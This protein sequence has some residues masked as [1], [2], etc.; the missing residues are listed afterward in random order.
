MPSTVSDLFS[1]VGLEPAG[2]VKWGEPLPERRVPGVYVVALS[3]DPD[4]T[5][6]MRSFPQLAPHRFEELLRTCPGLSLDGVRPSVDRLVERLEAFWIKDE[7]VLYIGLS[8]RPVGTRMREYYNTPLGANGP[9]KGGWWLKML[10][11]LDQLNVFW[12]ATSEFAAAEEGMLE[13]FAQG[14]SERSLA[15]L[16]DCEIVAPFANLR[17]SDNRIKRH[18]IKGVTASGATVREGRVPVSRQAPKAADPTAVST[19]DLKGASLGLTTRRVSSSDLA[20]GRIRVPGP[21]KKHLPQINSDLV[22]DVCGT[23]LRARC[24]P[25]VGTTRSAVLGFG[26]GKLDGLVHEGEVLVVVPSS[27]GVLRLSRS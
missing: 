16:Y 18:G 22:V 21:V 26:K 11:D 15:D 2:V 9:H 25:R 7:V 1:A 5:R 27:D 8:S 24:N 4:S 3:S 10:S 6:E 20:S 13:A 17:A 14:V 19:P 12:A 23:E